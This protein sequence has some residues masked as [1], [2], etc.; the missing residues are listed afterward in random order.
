MDSALIEL[1]FHLPS[2]ERAFS[3]VQQIE[4]LKMFWRELNVVTIE[5]CC[6][7]NQSKRT[8]RPAISPAALILGRYHLGQNDLDECS[9]QCS[10]AASLGSGCRPLQANEKEDAQ[11]AFEAA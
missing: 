1:S 3:L 6:V 10:E 4:H 5:A 2:H 11:Q 8:H 9:P 7:F